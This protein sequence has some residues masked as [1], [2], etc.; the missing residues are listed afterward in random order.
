LA[1]QTTK[2]KVHV[3]DTVLCLKKQIE[4]RTGVPPNEQ[5]L[6]YEGKQLEHKGANTLADYRV[7]KDSTMH[8]VLRFNGGHAV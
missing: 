2:Y 3:A 6:L 5:R 8:L 1:N 7:K 4:E